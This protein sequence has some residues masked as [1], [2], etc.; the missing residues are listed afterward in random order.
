M[1]GRPKK[2]PRDPAPTEERAERIEPDAQ[3]GGSSNDILQRTSLSFSGHPMPPVS[4]VAKTLAEFVHLRR[5]DLSN[6]STEDG[7][8][9]VS[10]DWLAKAASISRKKSKK[11]GQT[12]LAERL[13]WINLS[14]NDLGHQDALNGLEQMIALNVLT[15]SH[16]MLHSLPPGLGAMN[17][18]KALVLSHNEISKLPSVFPHLPELNTLVL[19]HNKIKSL[20][21]TLPTSLPSLK[22]LSLS[23]NDIQGALPDFTVCVHLRE[24]RLNGNTNLGALPEALGTWGRG[25]DGRAPGLVLLDVSDCGLDSRESVAP[26]LTSW[27]SGRKGLA[28]LSI[29]SNS[30]A[31]DPAICNKIMAAHPTLRFLD[32]SRVHEPISKEAVNEQSAPPKERSIEN[33]SRR[34]H[35]RDDDA[36]APRTKRPRTNDD[37]EKK[38]RK[39]SGR[40]KKGRINAELER[41]TARAGPP[42]DDSVPEHADTPREE[43]PART[44]KTRRS[45]KN[46]AV[47]LEMA[48]DDPTIGLELAEH[49]PES[50]PVRR[51]TP[52]PEPKKTPVDTGIVKVVDVA[53]KRQS[54]APS[55]L[56]RRE[57]VSLGGW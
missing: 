6:I 21:M 12:P 29:K 24:V 57:D 45:K 27:N 46:A 43:A 14:G 40:G 42:P 35:A 49:R 54:A 41:I 2:S 36:D 19:S 50:A 15:A 53:R 3:D 26:L 47:E 31:H 13:S 20:P 38:P 23:H 7:Q 52:S 22:K 10:L 4:A 44:K 28:N 51:R 16:C 9:L 37:D 18:L 56:A 39:R 25:V 1:P 30:V 48:D 55:V 5:L 33:K 17:S 8:G 34:V 11:D 32:N